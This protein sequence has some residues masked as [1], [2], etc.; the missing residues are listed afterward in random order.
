MGCIGLGPGFRPNNLLCYGLDNWASSCPYSTHIMLWGFFF[1]LNNVQVAR[2]HL[3]KQIV[4]FLIIKSLCYN[5]KKYKAF[6][7]KTWSTY[8]H[9]H[10]DEKY[11][12]KCFGRNLFVKSINHN[13]L[14]I[15]L[16]RMNTY[17]QVAWDSHCT[18]LI[19]VKCH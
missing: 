17:I 19:Q 9:T 7:E 1:F 6:F 12:D 15:L 5:K 2:M 3:K 18:K 16:I 14:N 13:T 10:E 11:L 4:T 8:M